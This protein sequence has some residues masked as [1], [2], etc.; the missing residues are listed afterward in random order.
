MFLNILSNT[1]KMLIATINN[2][3]RPAFC[4]MDVVIYMDVCRLSV[5]PANPNYRWIFVRPTCILKYM[6]THQITQQ[7]LHELFF[8]S[9]DTGRF[10]RLNSAGGS[11][12]GDVVKG[13]P[14]RQGYLR[15]SVD[16]TKYAYHT[17]V[18]LYVN[19]EI[20]PVPLTHSDGDKH[21]N[22]IDNLKYR[23]ESSVEP[24][25]SFM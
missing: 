11:V 1:R 15:M 12:K 25:V 16:G 22:R 20:P 9:S 8:Y 13:T 23:Y 3:A 18:W 6:K 21:N 17:L 2:L 7:R 19:G 24:V 10:M 14:H 5:R 4:R